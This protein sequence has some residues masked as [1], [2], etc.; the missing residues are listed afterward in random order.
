MPRRFLKRSSSSDLL[1]RRSA[2]TP[3]RLIYATPRLPARPMSA[4]ITVA[5][6]PVVSPGFAIRCAPFRLLS[7]TQSATGWPKLQLSYRRREQMVIDATPCGRDCVLDDTPKNQHSAT[8]TAKVRSL[9][10]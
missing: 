1:V 8:A 10:P 4:I 5:L 7:A 2:L 6:D 3:C 9:S